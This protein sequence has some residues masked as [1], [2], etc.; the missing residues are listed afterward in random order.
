MSQLNRCSEHPWNIHYQRVQF[1]PKTSNIL[2]K[3]FESRLTLRI[4]HGKIK[5]VFITTVNQYVCCVQPAHGPH[6]SEQLGQ[7]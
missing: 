2:I 6:L 1:G 4:R 5:H 3:Y 7:M